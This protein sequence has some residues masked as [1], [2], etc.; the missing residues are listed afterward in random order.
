[1][2]VAA[3]SGPV[4]SLVG[5][6]T[7]QARR[8]QGGRHCRRPGEMAFVKD[9]SF[10]FD[11]AIDHRAADFLASWRP[12]VRMASTSI[13]RMSAGAIWQAGLPLLNKVRA[14]ASLRPYRPVQT[15]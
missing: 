10:R 14:R 9:E 8:R 3:A 5:Q 12:P 11:A 6:K 4:G 2:V 7:G 15:V 13:S 1:V